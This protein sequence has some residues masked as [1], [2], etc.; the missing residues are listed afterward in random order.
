MRCDCVP[1][2]LDLLQEH[3]WQAFALNSLAVW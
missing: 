2:F 1:F 3:Y